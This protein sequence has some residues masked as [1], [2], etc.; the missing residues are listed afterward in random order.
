VRSVLLEKIHGNGISAI[1]GPVSR[2]LLR[3]A[4]NTALIDL[5]ATRD[6]VKW[7]EEQFEG[8]Q[9]VFRK[10]KEQLA[11]Q[12]TRMQNVVSGFNLMSIL[13]KA[14]GFNES[15]SAGSQIDFDS[16]GISAEE[17]SK[18]MFNTIKLT[19]EAFALESLGRHAGA[20]KIA[21]ELMA[22]TNAANT[23]GA[24]A[25][26]NRKLPSRRVRHFSKDLLHI[27]TNWTAHRKRRTKRSRRRSEPKSG[28]SSL[29]GW[30]VVVYCSPLVADLPLT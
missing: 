15:G 24:Q 19:A 10:T 7:I 5:L 25:P 18:V 17:R 6:L 29:W 9:F 4:L 14:Q 23:D 22:K 16:A 28:T 27:R 30:G 12:I 21:S 8:H 20:M 2:S 11:Q 26:Q 3:E 1:G 13:A